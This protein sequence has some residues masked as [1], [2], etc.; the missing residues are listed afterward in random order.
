MTFCQGC[1]EITAPI[2]QNCIFA[3]SHASHPLAL[4][5]S[6]CVR[7]VAVTHVA[8]TASPILVCGRIEWEM[9]LNAIKT[10]E[11]LGVQTPQKQPEK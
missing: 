4:C 10:I 11:S 7:A 5:F 2:D 6:T 9:L 3:H 1:D 8:Q